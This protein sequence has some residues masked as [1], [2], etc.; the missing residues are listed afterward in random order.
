M[1]E[2]TP[3]ALIA[4]L[5]A[6]IRNQE[7]VTHY[8]D[9]MVKGYSGPY[10]NRRGMGEKEEPENFYFEY[11][12][13]LLPRL[14]FN[15]PRVQVKSRRLGPQKQVADAIRHGLNRWCV[16]TEFR[17]VLVPSAV[18]FLFL[19]TVLLTTFEEE[20]GGD[21]VRPSRPPQFGNNVPH[22]PRVTHV[23]TDSFVWDP[24]GRTPMDWRW[25][26]HRY[27]R[28]KEDL[29]AEAKESPETWDEKMLDK[30]STS[31]EKET[32]RRR[33][34]GES[35]DRN[36][37]VLYEIW[38]PE[39]YDEDEYDSM[40]EARDAGFNG[41]IYTVAR[42]QTGNADQKLKDNWIRKPRSY[43]GP[44][45]GPYTYIGAYPV[46]GESN[47]LS[48]LLAVEA[49]TRNL[50]M[51]ARA[52]KDSSKSFKQLVLVDGD[53]PK[54]AQQIKSSADQFVIPVTGFDK[55]KVVQIAVG[56]A[57]QSQL[58][59]VQVFKDQLN[60]NAGMGEAQRGVTTGATATETSVAANS[61]ALRM[62]F[63]VQQWQDGIVRALRTVS[64]YLYHSGK[65]M[66]P[67]GEDAADEMEKD[68]NPVP[69][70][71]TPFFIGG[72]TDDESGATF[73]D[74]ELDIEPY[75][76][77]RT[78][79]GLLQRRTMELMSLIPNLVQ[80]MAQAPTG[81]DWP[82]LLDRIGDAFNAPG[83]GQL[84][85]PEELAAAMGQQGEASGSEGPMLASTVRG[86]AGR[87]RGA[88]GAPKQTRPSVGMPGQ[89][90]GG[91][92]SAAGRV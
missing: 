4:E 77:E 70:G 23:D 32:E 84:F 48:P 49:Q 50:N 66:I 47:R 69:E 43:Y 7:N 1:L 9:E 45:W 42:D 52:Y 81:V 37:V 61:S 11:T 78:D 92:L 27:V 46:P 85:H 17:K 74:L 21:G 6:G 75:S 64:W 10:Y 25:A 22:M 82:E 53:D 60:R 29:L 24:V 12:S 8:K 87:P 63:I 3:E 38:Y 39:Q 90:S 73:D 55:N 15:N 83:F 14:V 54:L 88:G 40:D 16:D 33:I 72:D 41:M 86:P 2:A 51:H 89:Q 58:E 34:R 30:I 68:G 35:P 91:M 28:D 62:D 80:M 56:G 67:L 76:M 59:S 79:Q 57:H 20:D 18:D 13:Y 26:G 31:E 19:H 36:E 44:R 5:E 71:E 65:V